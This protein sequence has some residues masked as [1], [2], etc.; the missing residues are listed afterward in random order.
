[1]TDPRAKQGG[2]LVVAHPSRA[3]QADQVA[4]AEQIKDVTLNEFVPTTHAYILDL[5][6]LTKLPEQGFFDA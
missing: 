2:K 3:A 5:D 1:V 6:E 4:A